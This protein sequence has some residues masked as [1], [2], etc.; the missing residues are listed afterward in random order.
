MAG[1]YDG[2]IRIDTSIETKDFNVGMNRLSTSIKGAMTGILRKVLATTATVT[3]LS[4]AIAAAAKFIF[5]LGIA[6]FQA[7]VKIIT[8]MANASNLTTDY[9]KQILEVSR[10]FANLKG[11]L[12]AAF[13]PLVVFALPYIK[14]IVNWLVRMLNI[15]AQVVAALLGQKTVMQ[16]VEGS[17]DSAA[18]STGKLAGASDRAAKSSKK[19]KENTEKTA[20]AAKGALA[21]FDELNVLQ[22]DTAEKLS[23]VSPEIP[24]EPIVGGGPGAGGAMLFKEVPIQGD[25]IKKID[26]IKRKVGDVF[27]FIGEK[28]D[29]VKNNVTGPIGD[30]FNKS[31]AGFKYGWETAIN[32]LKSDVWEPMKNGFTL[33]WQNIQSGWST[34]TEWLNNNVWE[35]IKR[36]AGLA[37]E[38]IKAGWTK[39]I[40]WMRTDVWEPMKSG[41]ISAWENIK[42]G[43]STAAEW[44]RTSVCEPIQ[45]GFET[46]LKWIEEKWKNVF[47]SVKDF[48]KNS[49]NSII[50]LI[51]GLLRAIAGGINGVI[52]SLN[53]IKITVP[54]W[55]PQYGGKTYGFS[56]PTVSA[57]TIPHL[58]TGAVI[59][60]NSQFAAILGDQRSGRNI[61]TPEA[62]M[63]QI[64]R[65]E[66]GK[67]M[68]ATITINFTGSMAALARELQP[69]I[70]KEQV[71]IGGSL[72]RS[73]ARI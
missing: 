24:E 64:V 28:T 1:G 41:F 31:I 16:Y 58:A 69:F 30:A 49:I 72:V 18:T 52:S 57:P 63:R 65:E 50:D 34:G 25:I 27:N 33:V 29:W 71:R 56:I 73:T 22:Q 6:A 15:I 8:A 5:G 17:A 70:E 60:P 20:K 7:G 2:S 3:L 36:D 10:A 46:A 4:V 11:A 48:V 45:K 21:V 26:E 53:S 13:S 23:E 39:G 68:E 42:S 51:N 12:Y 59:P 9:G 44:F 43:W 47:S 38:N 35:P 37:L 19:I 67:D 54:K 40:E 14:T 66:S 61:E 32:W 62:L 55:V